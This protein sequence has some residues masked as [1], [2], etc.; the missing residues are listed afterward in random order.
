MWEGLEGGYG[1]ENVIKVQ[2]WKTLK[3]KVIK[4]NKKM[5][6]DTDRTRQ[7]EPAGMN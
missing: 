5:I 2:S 3:N 4:E 7:Q 1:R 6:K